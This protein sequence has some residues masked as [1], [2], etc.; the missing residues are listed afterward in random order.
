MN[1]IK[2]AAIVASVL[3]STT[4]TQEL[5]HRLEWRDCVSTPVLVGQIV[6]ADIYASC[7]DRSANALAVAVANNAPSGNGRLRSFSIGFCG[8]PIVDAVSPE[9]WHAEID[10]SEDGTITWSVTDELASRFGVRTGAR[11]DGFRVQLMPRWQMSLSR[12]AGWVNEPGG[13]SET[14]HDC[15]EWNPELAVLGFAEIERRGLE[16]DGTHD[17]IE[18]IRVQFRDGT[19]GAVIAVGYS[20][21]VRGYSMLAYDRGEKLEVIQLRKD[22]VDWGVDSLY[23][24]N[25]YWQPVEAEAVFMTLDSRRGVEQLVRLAGAVFRSTTVR[26]DDYFELVRVSNKRFEVLFSA[27]RRDGHRK[28]PRGL[29]FQEHEYVFKNV[30]G[31]A[32]DEIVETVRSCVASGEDR[33]DQ[34]CQDPARQKIYRFDGRR[35]VPAK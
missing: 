27:A 1:A 28:S 12:S 19:D 23:Q 13:G 2:F 6:G 34:E 7:P 17:G 32:A 8:R 30:T 11:K 21:P 31:D 35:F 24:H 5:Q 4:A 15:M 25:D 20:D 14:T 10:R 18:T 16:R 33:T 22:A 9:G 29:E 26:S 3:A